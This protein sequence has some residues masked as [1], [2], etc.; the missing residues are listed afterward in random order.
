[1]VGGGSFSEVHIEEKCQCKSDAAMFA[2]PRPCARLPSEDPSGSLCS[3]NIGDQ[4]GK[5]D[6]HVERQATASTT[7]A[8]WFCT[9]R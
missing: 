9:R 4:G 7:V 8:L 1:M 5:Q 6:R 3:G 2:A